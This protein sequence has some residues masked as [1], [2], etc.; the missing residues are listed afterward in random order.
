[1]VIPL[2]PILLGAMIGTQVQ[3]TA[4]DLY[5]NNRVQQASDLTAQF[6][7]DFYQGSFNENTRFWN[8][9]IRRHHLSDR[10]IRYPYRTGYNFNLTGLYDAERIFTSNDALRL[11]SYFTGASRIANAGGF[12]YYMYHRLPYRGSPPNART[13]MMYG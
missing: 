9:Y 3:S 1:M 2:I 8:D 13:D 10:A 7:R 5:N 6:Q 11:G 4:V 12:S